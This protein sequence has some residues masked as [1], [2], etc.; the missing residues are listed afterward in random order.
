MEL[1]VPRSSNSCGGWAFW[2]CLGL[3][4]VLSMFTPLLENGW[5]RYWSN[6]YVSKGVP[7]TALQGIGIYLVVRAVV[8]PNLKRSLRQTSFPDFRSRSSASA[9]SRS[10]ALSC[11]EAPFG[12][13]ARFTTVRLTCGASLGLFAHQVLLYFQECWRQ[14]FVPLF[15]FTRPSRVVA[16]SIA[17]A[18]TWRCGSERLLVSYTITALII[19]LQD[20]GPRLVAAGQH[21]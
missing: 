2:L 13:Q 3:A 19:C 16:F 14:C 17:S 7:L 6:S 10:P 11:T 15:A 5:L 18:K 8:N 4:L 21:P 20:I 9:S 12:R 1:T